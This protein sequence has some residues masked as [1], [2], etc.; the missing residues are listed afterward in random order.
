MS[1]GD[2]T[3]R[4]NFQGAATT[5]SS[6]TDVKDAPAMLPPEEGSLN[7]KEMRRILASSFLGTAIEFYD[8][9]LYATAAAVVFSQVFFTV[10]SAAL[11]AFFSFGTLAAGYIARPLGGLVFGHFGDVLGRKKVLVLAM[12]LMGVATVGVGLLPTT[13]QIGVAAP[14]LLVTLRVIQGLA[15]GGE[16][17]GAM[18]VALEHAP[19][20]KRGFAASFANM[21]GPAGAV[22]ATLVVSLF[23]TLPDEQFLSWG[24][25]VPFLLSVILLGV[26]LIV[27]LQ[28]SETP[29]FQ[30]M[31]AEAERRRIP[32][33]EV[34]TKY[35]KNLV[36]GIIAG[37]GV[38][39][40]QG[41]MTVWAVSYVIG[42][43]L[44]RTEVLN[45]KAVA[46][47]TTVIMV[48]VSARMSDRFGR[49]P[50]MLTGALLGVVLAYPII[51]LVGMHEMWAFAL[52]IV[53][54]NGI[55]QGIVF[56]PFG[57]F[58]AELFPT[59]IRYTGAS[60][61]YQSSSTFGAGFTPAI[62]AWILLQ[63]SGQIWVIGVVWAAVLALTG[64]A[65]LMAK[66]GRG[67]DIS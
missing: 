58:C 49:K 8:F 45:W 25:R 36:I 13:A 41:L 63:T 24:W 9:I 35:P 50:V 31:E 28:V 2:P 21:G 37:L 5:T 34:I 47:T 67:R 19:G 17:G 51:A 60:L 16:W 66:E 4:Q 32:A 65:I 56:G 61:A 46:A 15:V 22:M 7:T 53:L 55:L 14:I 42:H 26:G 23:S 39:S 18:L 29:L 44:D 1:Y 48:I 40:V 27:R 57:A 52:A 54:S 64:V 59:R 11:A 43:G 12:T 10:D 3:P 33:L 30:K 62:A 6:S 20:G 38:Y